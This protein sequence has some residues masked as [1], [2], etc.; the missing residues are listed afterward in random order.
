MKQRLL[1]LVVVFYL[2]HQDFWLWRTAYPLAFGFL[3]IGLLYHGGYTL[4]C[5]ALLALLVKLAW[6][7]HLESTA[8]LVRAPEDNA[9]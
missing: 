7:S 9:R 5:S 8:P 6:P 2:L 3:P 4:A 1:I